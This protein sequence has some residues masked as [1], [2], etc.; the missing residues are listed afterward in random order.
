MNLQ[1]SILPVLRMAGI[2]IA[3]GVAFSVSGAVAAPAAS[4][5]G[6]LAGAGAPMVDT[7]SRGCGPGMVRA[8]N[9]RCFRPAARPHAH[10]PPA[11]VHRH[12]A[13]PRHVHSPRRPVQCFTQHTPH[14]PRRV[15][16]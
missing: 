16:R 1:K 15:C 12:R 11:H 8:A 5:A 7:V 10:R 4:G 13:P 9:G 14:G 2:A 6:S 3:A